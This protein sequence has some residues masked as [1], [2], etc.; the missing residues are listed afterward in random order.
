MTKKRAHL[1]KTASALGAIR[2]S[3]K[4]TDY[5]LANP[6][7]GKQKIRGNNFQWQSP[8]R[9]NIS[10]LFELLQVVVN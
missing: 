2:L 6:T 8:R 9:W 4:T 3:E 7:D 10:P 1:K 5:P